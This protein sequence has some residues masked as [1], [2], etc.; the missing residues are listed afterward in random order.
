M[1][2]RLRRASRLI[3]MLSVPCSLV[4]QGF[5]N[6]EASQTDPIAISADGTRLYAVNTPDHRLAEWS[7]VD[8]SRPVLLREIE[9]G[10]EPVSLALRGDDQAW[11][12]DQLSD[13][14]SVVS[15][16]EGRV[17]A[18]L[19]VGDEPG[20][21]AFA[22]DPERAF[23]S[24]QTA[25]EVAV[26]DPDSYRRVATIP[27]FGDDPKAL[28]ASADGATVWVAVFRSGNQTTVLPAHLAPPP[29]P[30]TNPRLG[31]APAQG[32]IIR[33]DDPTWSDLH[34]VV[35]PDVD[36]VEIDV[37]TLTVRREYANVG[38]ILFALTERPGHPGE[39]WVAQ[40]HGLNLIEFETALRGRAVDN[41]LA[42][43]RTGGVRD[44]TT[45]PLN[46]GFDYGTLP[47]KRALEQA[48]AYPTGVAFD[49]SGEELWVAAFG[50]DRLG[51]VAP[52]GRILERIEIG[53]AQGRFAEPRTKRGPRGLVHH[54]SAP[55]LYVLNRLSNTIGVVDTRQRRLIGEVAMFD[56]TPAVVREGRG[57]LYDAKLS[58]S[59]TFSCASCHVDGTTDNLAWVLGDRGG[60]MESGRGP[61]G[62]QFALHPMKGPMVT[63]TLQGL[64][65]HAP[66]HW[67]GDRSTLHD[68]NPAFDNLMGG[69]QLATNDIDDYVR[70]LESIEYPP[71]PNQRLD[72]GFSTEPP[73]LSAADGRRFFV[74]TPFAPNTRCV[75]CHALP[76]GSNRNII[77]P[78]TLMRSQPM[79]TAQL[80]NL[81]KRTGRKAGARGRTAG[82]GLAHDGEFDSVFALLSDP[83]FLA[84]STDTANKTRLMRFLES[85]DTGTAPAVG[86]T[87]ATGPGLVPDVDVAA[88]F[89][90]LRVRAIFRDC[91]VVAFVGD[92]ALTRGYRYAIAQDRFE[93]DESG[94]APLSWSEL[95]QL[96]LAAQRPLRVLGVPPGSGTRVAL[97]RDQDGHLD[98]DER[99]VAF[100]NASPA[101]ARAT[102][103]ANS[104][105]N[106]GDAGFALVTA[107]L[108]P[109]APAWTL[110]GF[111][112]TR[113]RVLDVEVLVDASLGDVLPTP[114]DAR[115]V[116]V[117]SLPIPPDAALRGVV[118]HAQTIY[119]DGCA[120]G[121]F[122][123]SH[124]LSVAID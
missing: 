111:A 114:V 85:F 27:I 6:Y 106:L 83:V 14:V 3:A 118:V 35:L 65:G 66:F 42:R 64:R 96:A 28:L 61:D 1:M 87:V 24:L 84:L 40:M 43:I 80:R 57:F 100:G 56:P 92:G 120:A 72:R 22:G 70:F 102:L 60:E 116:G 18:T 9:V 97:D 94:R 76:T 46:P 109:A 99:P 123:A 103:R 36:V 107:D 105:P 113:V 25:R 21:V 37:A 44:V 11:V 119:S 13:T 26:Y 53:P 51:V 82:F 41:E 20:D 71:N 112:T 47:N 30:P 54:P 2:P 12:V 38:T 88:S 23:V 91:D 73:G 34:D 95:T 17:I 19:R 55:R 32:M 122:A 101:C 104:L 67:R 48:L 4:A 63:Q 62:R 52:D 49:P 10:L 98:G 110:V 50:T 69:A 68:F 90:T 93:A 15:L 33:A 75:D 124:G 115:G 86:F 16:A 8:P 108:P 81:Y 29:L 58:G 45:I 78:G 5:V 74:E 39:V 31:P 89:A 79:K 117:L 59:G 121:G 7:L 77:D